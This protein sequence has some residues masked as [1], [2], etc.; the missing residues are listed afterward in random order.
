ML[1]S[2]ENSTCSEKT[3]IVF[4][5]IRMA[6]LLGV[7]Y[8]LSISH[9]TTQ[10]LPRISASANLM[11]PSK[12]FHAGAD[13]EPAAGSSVGRWGPWPF[14]RWRPPAPP[15]GQTSSTRRS[16]TFLLGT[17]RRGDDSRPRQKPAMI[18]LHFWGYIP[19]G[20]T[21]TVCEFLIATRVSFHKYAEQYLYLHGKPFP[22]MLLTR[23]W[24]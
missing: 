16:P 9:S 6:Q 8:Q 10:S 2:S 23:W 14:E 1:N 13:Q 24:F 22:T 3:E 7:Y 17:P 18:Y 21:V 4:I 5:V 11:L 12:G 20:S 15:Q 19:H